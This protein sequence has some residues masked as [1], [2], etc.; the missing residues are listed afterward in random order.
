MESGPETLVKWRVEYPTGPTGWPP[1]YAVVE[2]RSDR[3]WVYGWLR[4]APPILW[5][6][7]LLFLCL[8][9][10]YLVS[11]PWIVIVALFLIVLVPVYLDRSRLLDP[12]D[13]I[14]LGPSAV[15]VKRLAGRRAYI[16]ADVTQVEFTKPADEDYD[17]K[18]LSRRYVEVVLRFRQSRAYRLLAFP[19]EAA[20]I[21]TW[22]AQ[23]SRPI[24]ERTT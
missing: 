16:S 7:G 24:V 1:E 17:E 2:N 14:A 6:G 10:R 8:L 15:Y 3:V 4:L 19:N 21:A 13:F 22:A 11:E 9:G 18:Q 12:V 5:L 20:R 23:H